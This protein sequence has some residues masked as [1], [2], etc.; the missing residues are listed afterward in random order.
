MKQINTQYED[1]VIVGA[2]PVGLAAAADF[3]NLGIQP[4]VLEASNSFSD[5]SKA[6]CWSQRTLEILNRSGSAEKML[7]KGVTW[8]HGRVYRGHRE[9]YNFDLQAEPDFQMPAFINF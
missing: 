3:A 9:V 5:G 8:K 2:G 6:I 7:E 4:V 1:V